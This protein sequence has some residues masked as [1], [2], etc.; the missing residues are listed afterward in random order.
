MAPSIGK[1]DRAG[2]IFE[3]KYD[4]YGAIAGKH[5]GDMKLLSRRDINYLPPFPEIAACLKTLSDLVLDGELVVLDEVA[6]QFSPLRRRALMRDPKSCNAAVMQTPAA[7][8]AFD[9]VALRGKD[10]RRYPLLVRKEMLKDSPQGLEPHSLRPA[11][12]RAR[13]APLPGSGRAARRGDRREA[14]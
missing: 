5:R 9:L 7:V 10:L 6:A 14:G 1:A 2:W 13:R 8:F 4:G 12:R 11:H 3:L